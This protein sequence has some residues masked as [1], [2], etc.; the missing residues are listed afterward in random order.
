MKTIIL[1]IVALFILLSPPYIAVGIAWLLSIGG[2]DY[3][4]TVT[5]GSFYGL[6]VGY[7]VVLGWAPPAA[8]LEDQMM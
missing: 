5:D 7:Y 3:V 6:A 2:F 4:A 8:W 1:Y